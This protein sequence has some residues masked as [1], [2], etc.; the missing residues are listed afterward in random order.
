LSSIFE[1]LFFDHSRTA[2]DKAQASLIGGLES[3]L[4]KKK[5]KKTAADGG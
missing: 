3:D 2:V 4:N 5:I 1:P